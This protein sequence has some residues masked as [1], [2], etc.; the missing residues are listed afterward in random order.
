MFRSSNS[1]G[2]RNQLQEGVHMHRFAN[3]KHALTVALLAILLGSI[4][5]GQSKDDFAP[6]FAAG[7]E[8]FILRSGNAKLIL[9][10]DRVGM[11]PAVTYMLFDASRPCQ[12]LRKGRAFNFTLGKACASSALEVLLRGTP[13]TAL[14]Y[15]TKVQWSIQKG[16]PSV[17]ASWWAGGIKVTE[18][19]TPLVDA[20]AFVRKIT[21]QGRNLAGP[22]TVRLRLSLPPGRFFTRGGMLMGVAENVAM[23]IAFSGSNATV[24]VRQGCIETAAI[25]IA[26]GGEAEITSFLSTRIPA[27]GYSYE[28]E[29]GDDRPLQ[30][31]IVRPGREVSGPAGLKA[32]YFNNPDLQGQPVVVRVD[33]NFCPSWGGGSPAPEV[34]PDSFSLRWTGIIVPP[35]S[36]RYRFTVSADERARLYINDT[37]LINCWE[38]TRSVRVAG[39]AMLEAGKPC[40]I[41]IEFSEYLGW[42]GVRVRCSVPGPTPDEQRAASGAEEMFASLSALTTSH[43]SSVLEKTNAYWNHTDSLSTLDTL[44][45]SLYD[46]ARSSLPGMVGPDGKMD[47]GIFEYGD[48]WVRDGSNAV[49]GLL[50]AGHFESAR[51]VLKLILTDL[52]SVHGTMIASGAFDDPDREE[53]DQMGELLHA[54]KAYR[55]WTDDTLLIIENRE[56]ILAMIDRPLQERF[57]D[58]T[59]MLHNRREYWE[60]TFDDGY[61]LVYQAFMV[62]GLRDAV[63][64]S[65]L[66]GVP[67]K[68]SYW[69][70]QADLFRR[71]MLE[72][73]TRSLVDRG[74]L[75][76]RRNIDGSVADLIPSQPSDLKRD[77][78]AATESYH[79]LNPDAGSVL[80]ILLRVVDP[81]STLARGTLDRLEEIWNAR[82]EFGGYERYHS[83]SQQDQP[84]PWTFATAFIARAQQD[85]GLLDRS[86]RSLEWLRRIEGGNA[87]A[88][89]EEIPL[90]RSQIPAAGIVPWASAEVSIFTVRHWLGISF[91]GNDMVIRPALFAGQGGVTASLRFRSSRITLA[92][93]KAGAPKV[94]YVN[95]T[96]ILPRKDGAI[97]IPAGMLKTAVDI[98]VLTQ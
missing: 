53:F 62:S 87:G 70:A 48:Q 72:H 13:F 74:A 76:K 23:G 5:S 38:S 32:E 36:G 64:L 97:V 98:R 49:L 8:Y 66:L 90:N 9:Q 41:R 35:R 85:A 55:D 51:A 34:H 33:S 27:E 91:E 39:D 19:F 21:L 82:W 28:Q 46:N 22:D 12:T 60:R 16:V 65:G 11:N 83:S 96:R 58:S 47:A 57:R 75:I 79:R 92:I 45:K 89:F 81:G 88:W 80:P 44:V 56:K 59:G 26:P 78:P 14:G 3:R 77:D 25:P 20:N 84:G 68:A 63:E 73:P 94:V 15:T 31:A 6:S 40:N 93:D 61:E 42:A 71:A 30:P 54:L 29:C 18:S 2:G 43:L 37:L 17:V 1:R 24:D 86:R 69:R 10:S 67:E 7:R 95:L 4:G 50:H 52:V